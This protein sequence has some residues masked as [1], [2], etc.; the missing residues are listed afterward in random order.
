M[1]LHRWANK[2]QSPLQP[3]YKKI[4]NLCGFSGTVLGAI[5][6]FF[7]VRFIFNYYGFD[8]DKGDEQFTYPLLFFISLIILFSIYIF[9][10]AFVCH[11]PF[12]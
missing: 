10:M 7:T 5:L 9:S 8:L 11:L 2:Y 12:I 1:N 4:T 3:K 6:W